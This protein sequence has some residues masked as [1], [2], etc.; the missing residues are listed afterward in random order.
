MGINSCLGRYVSVVF[1]CKIVNI[2]EVEEE[3]DHFQN[4]L[5]NNVSVC[6]TWKKVFAEMF[7]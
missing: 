7:S 4:I 2:T 6:G 1:C 5:T 3:Q